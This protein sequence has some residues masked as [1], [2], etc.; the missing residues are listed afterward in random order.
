MCLT[1]LLLSDDVSKNLAWAEGGVIQVFHVIVREQVH[2]LVISPDPRG[3]NHYVSWG[4]IALEI[5][6]GS[7]SC[8]TRPTFLKI[9]LVLL[10]AFP[11]DYG[12][13]CVRINKVFYLFYRDFLGCNTGHYV[14]KLNIPRSIL[15][16]L[17]LD[18]VA[19][20]CAKRESRTRA[21]WLRVPSAFRASYLR[22]VAFKFP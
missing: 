4:C 16:T 17:H 10:L 11:N 13:A 2:S 18:D 5:E 7:G 19:R 6:T 12:R 21:T 8:M 15:S 14:S 3:L 20:K 1:V 9:K 22:S